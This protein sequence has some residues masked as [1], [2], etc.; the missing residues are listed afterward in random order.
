MPPGGAA[1]SENIVSDSDRHEQEQRILAV[2]GDEDVEPDEA[3]RH[4]YCHLLSRLKLP[5]EVAGIED[6]QWEE[7]YVFGPGNK[8]EYQALRRNRPSYRDIFELIAIDVDSE[9]EWSIFSDDLKA[10]V[11]RKTDGRKFILGLSE[12]KATNKNSHEYPLL[13]DYAVWLVNCR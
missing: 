2:I 13:H 3:I 5:C 11:R 8:T 9:S 6:F 1:T 7:F 12:L 10:H 4:W